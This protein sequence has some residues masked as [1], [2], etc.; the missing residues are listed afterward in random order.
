MT[1][2]FS[3]EGHGMN[4]ID[5]VYAEIEKV[6]NKVMR[7]GANQGDLGLALFRAGA[8]FLHFHGGTNLLEMA[9]DEVRAEAKEKTAAASRSRLSVIK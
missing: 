9:I 3:E 6:S 5:K 1:R 4:I 8:M 2:R 7:T